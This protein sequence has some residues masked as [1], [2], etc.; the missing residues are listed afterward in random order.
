MNR[1]PDHF[2]LQVLS[3]K[4][5]KSAQGLKFI[6]DKLLKTTVDR[7]QLPEEDH[8]QAVFGR[9]GDYKLISLSYS[10]FGSSFG[11]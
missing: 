5:A 3:A 10:V 9:A 7:S 6:K 2:S 8:Y 4:D 1:F 11:K